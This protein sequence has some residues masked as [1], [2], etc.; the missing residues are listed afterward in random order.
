M[1]Q[2]MRTL[3]ISKEWQEAKDGSITP[4]QLAT[5]IANKLSGLSSLAALNVESDWEKEDLIE[6]FRDFSPDDSKDSFDSLMEE[7]YDWAD[8]SLDG[9]YIGK[10]KVCWIKIM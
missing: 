5:V 7:L 8:I 2:W 3:D 6:A 1:S 9:Q 10:R 4:K